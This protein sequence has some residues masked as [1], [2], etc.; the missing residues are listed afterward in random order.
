[1]DLTKII[2]SA[3]PVLRDVEN[4]PLIDIYKRTVKN[5]IAEDPH[6]P[7]SPYSLVLGK[8][9][10]VFSATDVDTP[11]DSPVVGTNTQFYFLRKNIG[12]IKLTEAHIY[13]W[14]GEYY[15]TKTGGVFE[16]FGVV[17]VTVMRGN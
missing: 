15:I 6:A 16:M 1:M 9:E 17:Q 11:I 14:N 3:F 2:E 10:A 5:T 4:K 8:V 12:T 7:N 13:L